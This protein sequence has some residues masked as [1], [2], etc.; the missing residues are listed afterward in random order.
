M[1]NYWNR[2][3]RGQCASCTNQALVH[4]V[5]CANCKAKHREQYNQTREAFNAK[6][7]EKAFRKTLE[8]ERRLDEID[9]R[10]KQEIAELEKALVG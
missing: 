6:R 2:R 9:A 5:R 3:A 1:S 8:R 7:R 4:E 10:L